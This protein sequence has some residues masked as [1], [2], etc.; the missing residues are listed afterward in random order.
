MSSSLIGEDE[1]E[2]ELRDMVAETLENNGVLPRIRAQLRASVFLALDE[3]AGGDQTKRFR[4]APLRR[5]AS[6]AAGRR[7]LALVRELLACLQLDCTLSVLDAEL[8]GVAGWRE[9]RGRLAQVLGV[10][11]ADGQPVMAALLSEREAAGVTSPGPGSARSAASEG[12]V[13]ARSASSAE[14]GG[15][16]RNGQNG[17]SDV[18]DDEDSFF[19]SLPK[20]KTSGVGTAPVAT[21]LNKGPPPPKQLDPVRRNNGDLPTPRSELLGDLP[22]L[23]AHGTLPPL[24]GAQLPALKTAGPAPID[25]AAQEQD[26]SISEEMGVDSLGSESLQSDGVTEDVSIADSA[27]KADFM[28]SM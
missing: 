19:D 25:A 9:E 10:T 23:G 5:L 26:E 6:E 15:A 12:E 13:L 8:E 18:S 17:G 2:L 21:A 24:R 4:N 16:S 27:V 7:C 22:P 1:C 11:P 3:T 20:V 14:S 28:E